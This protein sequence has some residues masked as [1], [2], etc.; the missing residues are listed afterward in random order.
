M[1][2]Q[3]DLGLA[4]LSVLTKPGA[5]LTQE[6]IAAWCDCHRGRIWQIERDALRKLRRKL[7]TDEQLSELVEDFLCQ[8]ARREGACKSHCVTGTDNR[9][10]RL[11]ACKRKTHAHAKQKP[12][13][14]PYFFAIACVKKM[15]EF[16]PREVLRNCSR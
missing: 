14:A 12:P 6:D 11:C 4:L 2:T 3:I 7:E 9:S 5:T 8:A 13:L 15:A 1:K 10:I 16:Q